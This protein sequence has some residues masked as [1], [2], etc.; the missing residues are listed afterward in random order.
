MVFL[1]TRDEIFRRQVKAWGIIA[2]I[3]SLLGVSEGVVAFYVDFWNI[4]MPWFAIYNFLVLG[5]GSVFLTRAVLFNVG[6]VPNFV[7]KGRRFL[8][9]AR[10]GL[11][12][13]LANAAL[14]PLV[15]DSCSQAVQTLFQK[16]ATPFYLALAEVFP[17]F[18]WEGQRYGGLGTLFGMPTAP[19]NFPY[20]YYM[21][22]AAIVS[23]FAID[24]VRLYGIDLGRTGEEL[25]ARLVPRGFLGVFRGSILG[26]AYL[27]LRGYAK[28][29]FQTVS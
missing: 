10:I 14:F 23:Y 2:A 17:R 26:R 18:D 21:W 22:M 3:T 29:S 9:G 11:I 13:T 27:H 8:G 16:S 28:T 6:L 20:W 19:F 7:L 1:L 12:R 24:F 25:F 15:E 4:P 5:V